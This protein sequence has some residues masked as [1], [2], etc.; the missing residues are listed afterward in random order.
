MIDYRLFPFLSPGKRFVQR[1]W[2]IPAAIFAAATTALAH[3]ANHPDVFL[4]LF[5]A[6]ICMVCYFFIDLLCHQ[7]KPF[8][9][10]I[11]VAAGMAILMATPVVDSILIAFRSFLPA[12]GLEDVRQLPA[13]SRF[14]FFFVAA[15]LPEELA[16][17]I[18]VFIC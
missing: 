5:G 6:C 16:K 4:L 3:S 18:P 10:G 15:G 12:L 9:V 14:G 13:A 11:A 1:S 2:L 7:K 8:W 17:A